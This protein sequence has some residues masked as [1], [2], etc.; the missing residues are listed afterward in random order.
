[1]NFFFFF[2]LPVEVHVAVVLALGSSSGSLLCQFTFWVCFF[3][4]E[5]LLFCCAKL[6]GKMGDSGSFFRFSFFFANDLCE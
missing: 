5:Y 4:C 6:E 1:L 2:F 3:R